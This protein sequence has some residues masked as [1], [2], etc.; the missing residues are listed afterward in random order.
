MSF[1]SVTRELGKHRHFKFT[2]ARPSPKHIIFASLMFS[3][4][5]ACYNSENHSSPCTTIRVCWNPSCFSGNGNVRE[6]GLVF[7]NKW[8]LE[9]SLRFPKA[10]NGSGTK[11]WER[12]G[13]DTRKSFP[14]ISGTNVWCVCCA[15]SLTSSVTGVGVSVQSQ[16]TLHTIVGLPHLEDAHDQTQTEP[17]NEH[18]YRTWPTAEPSGCVTAVQSTANSDRSRDGDTTAS[19][20]VWLHHSV[21]LLRWTCCNEFIQMPSL[22][23]NSFFMP[24]VF[25]VVYIQKRNGVLMMS[26]TP[27]CFHIFLLRLRIDQSEQLEARF[28]PFGKS[29]PYPKSSCFEQR[30]TPV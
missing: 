20:I 25:N 22:F 24:G 23:L 21:R 6:L 1:C 17:D 18:S 14:H 27:I 15:I 8:E 2:L 10:G 7:R 28:S 4:T 30:G 9:H 11:S 29:I 5:T 12:E 3:L 16:Q 13:M 26:H 19:F